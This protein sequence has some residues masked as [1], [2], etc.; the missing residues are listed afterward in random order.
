VVDLALVHKKV[1][2]IPAL[3][4]HQPYHFQ[5]EHRELVFELLAM[6]LPP[7][8]VIL[9]SFEIVYLVISFPYL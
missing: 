6:I 8:L 1:I 3:P 4:V 5:R 9:I 2:Q 7:G